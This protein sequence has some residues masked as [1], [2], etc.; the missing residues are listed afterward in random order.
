MAS[1]ATQRLGEAWRVAAWS[2][3][4]RGDCLFAGFV[5]RGYYVIMHA[6]L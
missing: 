4:A 1:V 5:A 2:L 6:L 3:E